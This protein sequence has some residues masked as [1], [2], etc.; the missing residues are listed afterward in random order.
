VFVEFAHAEK[1]DTESDTA[2]EVEL[3]WRIDHRAYRRT[4]NNAIA[5]IAAV[6][7]VL[8]GLEEK[9]LLVSFSDQP[10]DAVRHA[11]AKAQYGAVAQFPVGPSCDDANAEWL[12]CNIKDYTLFSGNARIVNPLVIL[13]PVWVHHDHVDQRAEDAHALSLQRIALRQV[14]Y[15]NNELASAVVRRSGARVHNQIGRLLVEAPVA[16]GVGR[17]SAHDG[18][19][20]LERLIAQI[21]LTVDLDHLVE[22][23][24]GGPVHPAAFIVRISERPGTDIREEPWTSYPDLSKKLRDYTRLERTRL[25]FFVADQLAHLGR[26]APVTANYAAQHALMRKA[27]G[28][29][30]VATAE[31]KGMNKGQVSSASAIH[32]V[33]LH[34]F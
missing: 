29:F 5:N 3:R 19:I 13:H 30:V 12:K 26:P 21:L 15:L 28:S 23:L 7:A 24:Y 31:S 18:N 17:T 33:L 27:A 25:N 22:R 8:Y 32:E 14:A 1:G 20:D 4:K 9:I 16:V 34:C 6:D 10:S 11:K 2:V